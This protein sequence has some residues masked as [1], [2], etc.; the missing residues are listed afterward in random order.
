MIIDYLGHSKIR[1]LYS[2]FMDEYVFGLDV[3][4]YDVP[5]FQEFQGN[6]HLGNESLYYLL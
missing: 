1:D 2:I 6:D 3:P 5:L 4:V